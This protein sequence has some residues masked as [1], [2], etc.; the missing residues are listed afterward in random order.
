MISF[1]NDY[2]V[3]ACPQVLAA[4]ND[5]NHIQFSG[6]GVDEIC[7]QATNAI[8]KVIKNDT[9]D[10]HYLVGG[11]QANTVVI[12]SSLRP[13]EAVIACDSGHINVH[14]TGSI[15]G[16][17]HK[18]LTAP[19]DNGK[20]KAC[21]VEKMVLTHR[22]EHMV[23]PKMV[24]I[25]NATEYGTIYTLA[26][27][28]ALRAVCDQYGLYLFL[29]GA[30]LGSAIMSKENDITMA[31]LAQL[32]DVFYIG[33]TKNGALFG[34]AVVIVNDALKADF[35]YIMKQHGALLAKGW[36]L[37]LQFKVLFE[38]DLYFDLAKNA[39]ELAQYLQAELKQRN[40]PFLIES[41]TNQI[42][43]IV[44]NEQMEILAKKFKFEIWEKVDESHTCI[45]FVC[46]FAT[47]MEQ[48]HTLLT[49]FE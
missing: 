21:D 5:M 3:G 48:I 28:K 29:D 25:S 11:T 9:C 47:N 19:H 15:E 17:G 40:V 7:L 4:L 38:N 1:C 43:P 36:L 8:Q 31:D 20:L 37:G 16:V 10:V 44:S 26:E 24:Y 14:E 39:D 34:E 27:L 42:F 12:K 18:V 13:H 35:R 41:S 46:S 30:R 32:C 22:D 6:Y 33:G 23:K 2:C 49:Y 45:R